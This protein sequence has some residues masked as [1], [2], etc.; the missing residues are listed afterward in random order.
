M[1]GY[2]T[3]PIHQRELQAALARVRPAAPAM[4]MRVLDEVLVTIGGDDVLRAELVDAYLEQGA[5]QLPAMRA[6][7]ERGE[8][9]AVATAAHALRSGSAQLGARTLATLLRRLED[10]ARSG[11]DR[12][13]TTFRLVLAEYA[14]VRAELSHQRRS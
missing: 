11:E 13:Q 12:V 9:V 7:L 5:V 8:P 4:D 10:E 3:K 1:D 14:R 2:L 6:G